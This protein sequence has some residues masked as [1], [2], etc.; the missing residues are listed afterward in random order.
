MQGGFFNS[1]FCLSYFCTVYGFEDF[2]CTYRVI[3]RSI[4]RHILSDFRYS[5]FFFIIQYYAKAPIFKACQIALHP[6]T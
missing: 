2:D 6:L 5:R 1:D 3:Q 4:Y